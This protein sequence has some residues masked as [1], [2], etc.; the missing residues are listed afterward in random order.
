MRKA[1]CIPLPMAW[2]P[3]AGVVKSEELLDQN[4]Q[5]FWAH[6]RRPSGRREREGW[7]GLH[8]CPWSNTEVDRCPVGGWQA[9]FCLL[10][11]L[12]AVGCYGALGPLQSCVGLLS[13]EIKTTGRHRK[14]QPQAMR[15]GSPSAFK[16]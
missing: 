15:K 3:R 8:A 14:E 4:W 11:G 2:A 6:C 10:D 5:S 9:E 12:T 1:L 13:F 16:R 7:R